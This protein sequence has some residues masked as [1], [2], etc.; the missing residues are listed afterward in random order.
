MHAVKRNK[1]TEKMLQFCTFIRATGGLAITTRI[2]LY[3]VFRTA[4]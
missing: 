1:I 2:V 3:S 4:V